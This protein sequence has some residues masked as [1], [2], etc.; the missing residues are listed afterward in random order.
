M[1]DIHKKSLEQADLYMKKVYKGDAEN[2]YQ[3][4]N[5]DA[6]CNCRHFR[7]KL[8]EYNE[9]AWQGLRC[10]MGTNPLAVCDKHEPNNGKSF[11]DFLRFAESFFK[12]PNGE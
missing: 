3:E 9:D 4:R 7:S 1:L 8:I 2:N 6:C 5:F 10:Q 11:N 12:Q